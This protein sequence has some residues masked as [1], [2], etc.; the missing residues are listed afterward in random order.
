VVESAFNVPDPRSPSL[1]NVMQIDVALGPGNSGGPLV[2][3]RGKLVGINTAIYSQVQGAQAQGYA[4]GVDRVKEV[5]D[6]LREERSRGWAGLALVVPKKSELEKL[7]LPPGIVA[8]APKPGSD[9]EAQG[10]EE[11]LITS[12]DDNP[13]EADMA[14]YCRAVNDVESGQSVPVTLIEAPSGGRGGR[15]RTIQLKFE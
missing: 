8:G 3:K 11:V 13:V 6:D 15:E 4:I 7:K 9:A 14:S 2:D 1:T 5:S 10:L 12:I